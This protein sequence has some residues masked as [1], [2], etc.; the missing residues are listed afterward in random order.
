VPS[1][2]TRSGASSASACASGSPDTWSGAEELVERFIL[3]TGKDEDG[4][5]ARR[6]VEEITRAIREDEQPR[7]LDEIPLSVFIELTAQLP[8]RR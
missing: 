6:A 1:R 5:A 7:C 8:T 3:A 2:R 4:E